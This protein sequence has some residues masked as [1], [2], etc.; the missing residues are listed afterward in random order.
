M[1]APTNA[2][3][4]ADPW[5][6]PDDAEILRFS[7][8]AVGILYRRDSLDDPE[9]MLSLALESVCDSLRTY[10]PNG[11]TT[12][13]TYAMTHIRWRIHS[14]RR[15]EAVRARCVKF[16]EFTAGHEGVGRLKPGQRLEPGAPPETLP[17]ERREFWRVALDGLGDVDATIVR[18]VFV[19]GA[20]QS[21]IAEEVGL[22]A[23]RVGQRLNG[24]LAHVR[25]NLNR[26]GLGCEL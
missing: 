8:W 19:D 7:K 23:S 12:W 21:D 15:S 20:R 24:G 3:P 5:T 18:R 22:T 14:R 4:T 17:M 2:A 13:R 1:I 9:E 10:R 16:V 26:A 6:P 11:G 25:R